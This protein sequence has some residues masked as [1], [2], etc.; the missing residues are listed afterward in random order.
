MPSVFSPVS[1]EEAAAQ[2]AR[3]DLEDS[4]SDVG[5]RLGN[6]AEKLSLDN[7]GPDFSSILGS[8]KGD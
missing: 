7:E 6:V 1:D 8:Q 4:F 2:I 5:D 3:E